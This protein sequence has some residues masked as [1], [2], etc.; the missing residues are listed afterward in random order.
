MTDFLH[1]LTKKEKNKNQENGLFFGKF[2]LKRKDSDES[3]LSNRQGS[4]IMSDVIDECSSLDSDVPNNNSDTILR[5][6]ISDIENEYDSD[7]YSPLPKHRNASLRE[8]V[9]SVNSEVTIHDVRRCT[10]TEVPEEVRKWIVSTFSRQ[11][12]DE[13]ERKKGRFRKLVK[14]MNMH[15]RLQR[16]FTVQPDMSENVQQYLNEID[17]WHWNPF[18]LNH[19]TGNRCLHFTMMKLWQRYNFSQRFKIAPQVLMAYCDILEEHYQINQAPYH[20]NV[21]ACDVLSTLHRLLEGTQLVHWFSDLELF[22]ML[23]AAAIHD[24][25]H[26]G[27]NNQFHINSKSE[28]ALLYNDQSVLE[29]HHIS[30]AFRLMRNPERNI[31]EHLEDNQYRDFRSNVV[32]MVL[33]TDMAN[34]FEKVEVIKNV[35]RKPKDY[36]QSVLVDESTEYPRTMEKIRI[37]EL[38]LHC[39]DISNCVKPWNIHTKFTGELLEEFFKQG[40]LEREM[41]LD[42]SP[43]CD[44][45][46][47]NIPQ[48]QIGFITYIIEPT[49]ALLSETATFVAREFLPVVLDEEKT[50]ARISTETRFK[51]LR[52]PSLNI[53]QEEIIIKIHA[54]TDVWQDHL[55]I[56]KDN[57]LRLDAQGI[58]S[59]PIVEEEEPQ[60]VDEG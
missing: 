23:F 3:K 54:F 2:I 22:S 9:S 36:W 27:T 38:L 45:N 49:F 24:L 34:H 14:A 20:N 16:M 29:N 59:V 30:A 5:V 1:K 41:E 7:V 50:M 47:I 15:L 28:L 19:L 35:I 4:G 60:T 44:R 21:H 43:L 26:T 56:N 40:D 58:N 17:L 31:L 51:A 46:T 42:I 48:S 13:K 8:R 11:E 53:K 18:R 12:Q 33:S 52:T 39:A 25:E 6:E 57:W 10:I 32:A 55:M 37:M